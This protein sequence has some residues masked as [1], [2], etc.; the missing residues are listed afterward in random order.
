MK[1][2]NLAGIINAK[3]INNPQISQIEGFCFDASKAKR[4]ECFFATNELEAKLAAKNG[5]YAIVADIEPFD[6]EIAFLRVNDSKKAILRLI[7]YFIT[8][9]DLIVLNVNASQAAILS[10]F[11]ADFTLCKSKLENILKHAMSAKTKILA[12]KSAFK[13]LSFQSE[14]LTEVKSVK[15]SSLSL[16]YSDFVYN[17]ISY[18]LAL[19]SVFVGEF[20]A[21]LA[22]FH[23]KNMNFLLKDFKEF[24]SFKPVFVGLNNQ[25]VPSSNRAFI[26]IKDAEIFEFC[27]SRL[28]FAA[29]SSVDEP[30]SLNFEKFVLVNC[31]YKELCKKLKVEEIE[32]N[33]F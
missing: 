15:S 9:N 27:A 26:C 21:I 12:I 19:P 2:Q 31:D 30:K 4:G 7:R 25:I 29:F 14:S 10:L 13:E 20:C 1:I 6:D 28:Q 17:G 16:F 11:V 33:L 3:L 18:S 8:A 22:F 23:N 5:A 32:E 24:D